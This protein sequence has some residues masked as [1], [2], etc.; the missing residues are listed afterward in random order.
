MNYIGIDVHKSICTA[1][2]MNDDDKVID[3]I[4][5]F[6]TNDEGFS[7]ITEHYSPEDSYILFE[8]LTTA[9]RVYHFFKDKGYRVEGLNT[10]NGCVTEISNTDFKTDLEDATKLARMCKDHFTGRR[11]YSMAHFSEID[12]M[13]AKELCRV[14]NDCSEQ[15]DKLN[16]RIQ[17]YMDLFGIKL[18]KGLKNVYSNKAMKYLRSLDHLALTIMV[19]DMESAMNHIEKAKAGLE[20]LYKDNEDVQ[21]LMSIKGIAIQTAATIYTVVDNIERFETPESLVSYVGL[22]ITRH[23]S[24]GNRDLHGHINKRGD[25]LVRKYL[26]N[27]VVKHQMYYPDSD[28]A[29]FYSRK[30]EEMPHWKAVTATMRKLVCIIWAMLTRHQVYKFRPAVRSS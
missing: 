12:S 29:K 23:E 15:R 17:A 14:L 5:D 3:Q 21:N 28:L 2:V 8:N 19:D 9:H 16:L 13:K 24:G 1:V 10:G 4:I 20:E 6:G 27:V 30:K 11:E 25:P 26:A 7:F 18:P 22:K